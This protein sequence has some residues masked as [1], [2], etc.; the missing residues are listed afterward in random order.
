M[1]AHGL[2]AEKLTGVLATPAAQTS[3]WRYVLCRSN[4]SNENKEMNHEQGERKGVM[5]RTWISSDFT[6]AEEAGARG[7]GGVMEGGVQLVWL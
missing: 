6:A 5:R 1:G 3:P 4:P 2:P 7:V